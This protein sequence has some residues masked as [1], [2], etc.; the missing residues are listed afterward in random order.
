[1][2][3]NDDSRQFSNQSRRHITKH[4]P[5]LLMNE[6]SPLDLVDIWPILSVLRLFTPRTLRAL[7]KQDR[8]NSTTSA[9][10][11]SS[12]EEPGAAEMEMSLS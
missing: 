6:T 7:T 11:S 5:F 8:L 2:M 12:G 9:N 4:K 10:I 1:M 3:I